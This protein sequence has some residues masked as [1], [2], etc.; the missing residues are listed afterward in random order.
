MTTDA[1]PLLTRML[2]PAGLAR[3]LCLQSA[4]YAVGSGVF[5]AGNAVFFTRVV[6]L[7]AAQV[8]IGISVAGFV[9]FLV[10]VP[11]GKVADRFGPLRTWAFAALLEAVVY[12]TYPW[13]RGLTGFLAVVIVLAVVESLGSSGRG[14]YTLDVME[15]GERVRTLAYVRSALNVGFTVGALLAG[16]ALGVGTRQ[17]LLAVPLVTAV[18]CLANATLVLRLP[19]AP[20]HARTA[21][22]ARGFAALRDRP[23]LAVSLLNGVVV[24]HGVLMTVT[25][26]LWL[27]TR[28]DAP[29]ALLAWLFA[30]NTV[31]AVLLQV[32]A[33]R[34]AETVDGAVRAERRAAVVLLA[35]CVVLMASHWTSSWETVGL[36]AAGYLG[37]TAA[38]LWQSAGAWGL[39]AELSPADRRAE[40]QGAFRLGSQLQSMVAPAACT[41]LAVTWSPYGWLVIGVVVLVAGLAL[42]YAARWAVATRT[43]APESVPVG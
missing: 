8:G 10:S 42:P 9:S 27:V 33:S 7:S 28:T 36:L 30:M 19:P 11:L 32:P 22:R 41:A 40:Y 43:T 21:D 34:G 20:V 16:V 17:A 35:G 29:H 39:M 18:V 38:E 15:Q 31:V 37:L 1:A 12:L 6:G 25:V 4:L 13:V 5:L 23:F 3:R 2:P 26:P 14:A 24:S